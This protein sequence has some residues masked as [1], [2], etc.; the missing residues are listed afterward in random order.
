[1][2]VRVLPLSR[3]LGLGLG[4]LASGM[5]LDTARAASAEPVASGAPSTGSACEAVTNDLARAERIARDCEESRRAL[6][7]ECRVA[8]ERLS[9]TTLDLQES[10]AEAAACAAARSAICKEAAA[11]AHDLALGRVTNAGAC[12]ASGDQAQLVAMLRGW[13][14]ASRA[15]AQLGAFA[16]GETDLLPSIG[17][18]TLP[19]RLVGRLL[20]ERQ[21]EPLLY[22]RLLIQALKYAAPEAWSRVARRGPPG[23]QAWFSSGA[24]LDP[25]I[26]AEAQ[27]KQ[28]TSAAPSSLTAALR[29]ATAYTL[30][31]GCSPENPTRGCVRAHQLEQLIESTGP[32][33]VRRRIEEIWAT[34]C[35]DTSPEMTL[36]WLEDLPTAQLQP[37]DLAEMIDAIRTKLFTCYLG[38]DETEL[39]Y[40]GWLEQALPGPDRVDETKLARIDRIRLEPEEVAPLDSC[41]RLAH[42][43]RAIAPSDVC[44]APP[45]H[46][47]AA[48]ISAPLALREGNATPLRICDQYARG[49]WE[50]QAVVVPR[51]FAHVPAAD[52]VVRV[53]SRAPATGLSHLRRACDNRHGAG[54]AFVEGVRALSRMARRF[55][56][57]PERA[58]WRADAATGDP[59]E[60]VRFSRAQALRAWVHH[61]FVRDT[62]CAALGLPADRC[63]LC[64]TAARGAFFDCDLEQ[65]LEER[66]RTFGRGLLAALTTL[67]GC[68]AFG[69]WGLRLRRARRT[70][71]EWASDAGERLA[72]LRL[73]AAP[74][75]WRLLYPSR[76]DCL[77]VTLPN[78][79]AWE[80]WGPRAA[81]VRVN[82]AAR[83]QE[84][85]VHHA[86]SIGRRLDARVVFLLHEDTASL[87]FGAVRAVLDW[88]AK[89][90]TRQMHVL[91]TPASRLAWARTATDLLEL[92]E[93][94]SLRGNPFE[95]RGRIT[96]SSQ[97]WN[98]EQLVSGLLAEIRAGR[99]HVVTGLR[100]FG[101]SSLALEVARRLPGPSAYVDLA[102]FHHEIAFSSDASQ[103]V[104]AILRSSCARLAD[105]ARALYPNVVVPTLPTTPFDAAELTRWIRELP[106]ACSRFNDGR[107]PPMLLV[108]DEIEQALALGPERLGH[109]LDVLSILLGRLRN[110]VADAPQPLG[111]PPVGLLLCSALHPLLWAPLRTLG[112]QSI[113]GTFPYVCVPRLGTEAA[114]AMMRGL[115]A[116]Q[117]IR[118]ADAALECLI[119]ETQGVPLLLRRLGTTILELYD[120][121]HARQGSLGAV[122]VGIEGAREALLREEREGS[123][124]RVWIE[125][126]I[127]E[128]SS[129][130]GAMLRKL[131]VEDT[132]AATALS[133]L[134]EAHVLAEFASS[135]VG[136][137]LSAGERDR[138]A[139]E[140]ARVFVRLLSDTKLLEPIGDLTAPDAYRL[141][142]GV[143]RRILARAVNG[144]PSPPPGR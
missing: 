119:T 89:V 108:L 19:E 86:V 83:V 88:A 112:Q 20:G 62:P 80:R 139:Q 142:E 35:G 116:R 49:L 91:P 29:L 10:K 76:H 135:G 118:F 140:A 123:P 72:A 55:G 3:V 101:K 120:A 90:G 73:P 26:A 136:A 60:A 124:L 1:M 22:R 74:D 17:A 137:R 70:F 47:V 59:V 36:R 48:V 34:D 7:E 5:V 56:E 95:V 94:S 67:L 144:S 4:V 52:E 126:E 31:A 111:S 143:L 57:S 109:A 66:W 30:V 125:S 16:A 53:D 12:I 21:R 82:E 69:F 33:L 105:S 27:R 104:D 25:E 28:S 115:G 87:D 99:W 14:G 113:M 43:L 84:G 100:R 61:E 127:A 131:A 141:P 128:P 103:A 133:A 106:F 68:I 81:V 114:G 15:L 79:P 117:G 51:A 102:G 107:P 97:F 65:R 92:V 11:F 64:L 24:P 130:A 138:R 85:D 132:V 71:V 40:H 18:A 32:L 23:I 98:R 44:V 38:E 96:S 54:L 77:A 134:A 78:E 75:P 41:A 9:S 121:D 8:T 46:V 58:P 129:A 37:S 110:A 42:A 13:E 122:Q 50:G 6:A 2:A 39:G 93:E 63:Q 45:E